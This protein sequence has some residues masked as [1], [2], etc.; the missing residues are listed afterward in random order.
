MGVVI[1]FVVRNI[2]VADTPSNK[3]FISLFTKIKS[4]QQFSK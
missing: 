3:I 1:I 2:K 4:I